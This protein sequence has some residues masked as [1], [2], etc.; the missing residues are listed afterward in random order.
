MIDA[1]NLT[2]ADLGRYQ[3][4]LMGVPFDI[5]HPRLYNA[6]DLYDVFDADEPSSFD[7]CYDTR[8]YKHMLETGLLTKNP[9]EMSARAMHDCN[10][11]KHLQDF[12]APYEPRLVVGIMGGHAMLRTDAAYRQTVEVSKRLTEKGY[13]MISG[14]GPGAMEATHLGAWMAGRTSEEVDDAIS[15]LNVAPKYCD[16]CWLSSALEVM[17]KYPLVTEYKSLSI[18]TWFYGHEPPCA[19]ATHTA[20]FFNNSIREDVILTIAYGGLI[21][22]PGSA[23]TIQEIF[24]EAVQDHYLSLGYASPM[25]FVGKHFW[26]EEIPVFPF[27]QHMIRTGKYK[28]MLLS[29]VDTTD[30][31][32]KAI[33]DFEVVYDALKK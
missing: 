21:Y 13:L 16:A 3:Q 26:T 4:Y 25:V 15:I 33:D 12:L 28:N 30:E 7:K 20:K 17:K 2:L 24:Q 23:G 19:F 27:M 9:W 8:V 18:P 10:I 22:M 5:T 29:L 14:G 31:I 1:E 11:H 32:V 6:Y